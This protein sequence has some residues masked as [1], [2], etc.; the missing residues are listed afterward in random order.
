MN[1]L[2][3]KEIPVVCGDKLSQFVLDIDKANSPAVWSRQTE[4]MGGDYLADIFSVN[5]TKVFA[6][7]KFDTVYDE[8]GK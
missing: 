5:G 1:L 6:I 4:L 7:D 8:R 2:L 3:N